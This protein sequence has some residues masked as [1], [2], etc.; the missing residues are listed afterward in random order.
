MAKQS[1]SINLLKTD[2]ERPL[3]QVINWTLTIGRILIISVELIA[4]LA[5]IYR[6]VLDKQLMD[7]RSAI[8][9]EQAIIISEQQNEA[10]Y[11]NLQDRLAVASTFSELGEQS[12]KAVKD[13]INFAPQGLTFTNVTY[14][15]NKIKIEANVNSVSS[16]SL[17]INSLKT[18]PLTDTVSIDKIENKITNAIIMVNIS[19]SLKQ[20]GGQNAA[21]NN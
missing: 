3:D 13:V 1:A 10:K 5:F 4:L 17:F 7:L 20:K 6:F 16:L 18:Y 9:Q 21:A 14:S 8:K 12:I 2:T 19:M 11:R 15:G